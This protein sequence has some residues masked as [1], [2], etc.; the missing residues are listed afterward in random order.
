MKKEI[1]KE[2][3]ISEVLVSILMVMFILFLVIFSGRVI[4]IFLP[5]FSSD[6]IC[7][8]V[9]GEDFIA[10]RPTEFGT[11]CSE[12]DY[13]NL[14][15]HNNKPYPKDFREICNVPKFWELKRWKH[16]C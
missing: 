1:E 11:I 16:D 4:M 3:D 6:S 12:R 15:L 8:E 2:N 13:E 14:T 9:Y 10:Q 7:Q 5:S